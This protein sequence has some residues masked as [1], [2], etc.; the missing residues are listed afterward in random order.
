MSVEYEVNVRSA[1][2]CSKHVVALFRASQE[3]EITACK[4]AGEIDEPTLSHL[5][6]L[7]HQV[8]NVAR[9]IKP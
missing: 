2:P 4:L 1:E 9:Q 5:L 6:C 7:A 3:I 8:A